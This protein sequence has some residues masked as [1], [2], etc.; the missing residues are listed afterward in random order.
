VRNACAAP[1][2]LQCWRRSCSSCSSCSGPH[3]RP[4]RHTP[5]SRG[6]CCCSHVLAAAARARRCCPRRQRCAAARQH[7]HI[8][9]RAS[10]RCLALRTQIIS[11]TKQQTVVV[12]SAMGSTPESP[13]KVTD[14]FLNMINKAARQD[15]AFLLDLAALQVRARAR[16]RREGCV[17]AAGAAAVQRGNPGQRK[18]ASCCHAGAPAALLLAP[19]HAPVCPVCARA[20]LA[21]RRSTSTRP[22]RC[23][24]RARS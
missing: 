23:W 2:G 9:T 7:R 14:L 16:A 18:R 19:T 22:R 3:T 24:A 11:D 8:H 20:V 4:R 6:S 5:P 12:V 15:A 21:H 13:V 17:A 10:A 1:G